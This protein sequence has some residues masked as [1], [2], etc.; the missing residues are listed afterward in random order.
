MTS[1]HTTSAMVILSLQIFLTTF[2]L[3][4]T[5]YLYTYILILLIYFHGMFFNIAHVD[6]YKHVD[7]NI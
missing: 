4:F 5:L 1:E 2:M 7:G 3:R 6:R